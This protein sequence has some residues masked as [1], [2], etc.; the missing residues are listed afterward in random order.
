MGYERTATKCNEFVTDPGGAAG[1]S[2]DAT[3]PPPS[4]LSKT[5]GGG[6]LLAVGRGGGRAL[7]GGGHYW[8][9]WF[10]FWF[11]FW[12]WRPIL[13][14]TGRVGWSTMASPTTLHIS[15]PCYVMGAS[16]D[17]HVAPSASPGRAAEPGP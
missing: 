14:L 6:E 15:Q 5:R 11:W 4:Y 10:W 7:G 12:F 1:T 3:H 16:T 9:L 2:P 13:R 17:P 8:R